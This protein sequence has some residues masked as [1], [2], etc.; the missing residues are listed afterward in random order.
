ML[1]SGRPVTLHLCLLGI[2]HTMLLKSHG[3]MSCCQHWCAG[4]TAWC[5]VLLSALMCWR[6]SM[7]WCV[8]STD[9][10]KVHHGV[11]PRHS[12]R[13]FDLPCRFVSSDVVKVM[14]LNFGVVAIGFIGRVPVGFMLSRGTKVLDPWWQWRKW[15]AYSVA[16]FNHSVSAL[17]PL[18]SLTYRT[19]LYRVAT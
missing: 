12:R 6:Y 19:N 2:Y 13:L 7:V 17:P 3:V 9:V 1:I 18:P 14:N 5:D 10:L 8:V 11:M 15:Q 16:R 4:G